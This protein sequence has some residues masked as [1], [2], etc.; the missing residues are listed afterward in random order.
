VLVVQEELLQ[1][2]VLRLDQRAAYPELL[3]LR[4]LLMVAAM[5]DHLTVVLVVLVGP[6]VVVRPVPLVV[7]LQQE[8]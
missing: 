5:V 1:Q 8:T 2:V 4:L 6:A 7:R 3:L